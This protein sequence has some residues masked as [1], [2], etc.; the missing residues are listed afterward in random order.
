MRRTAYLLPALLMALPQAVRKLD[1]AR[2]V[3]PIFA[4]NCVVCHGPSQQ[5]NGLRLDS[6]EA[7]LKGSNAGPVVV[8]GDSAGSRLVHRITSADP[9]IRMPLGGKPL[10]PDQIALLRAWIEQREPAGSKHWSFQPIRRS[11]VPAVANRAWVRNPI[12]AFI[13]ARLERDKIEPSAEADAVTL[14]RRVTLDLTGL[15]PTPQDAAE[16]LADQRP[17]AYERL[18]DRLL[19]SPHYGEK[20]ARH[21]LDLARYADSDGY[22][23]DLVRGHA[24]RYRHW[25]IDALN[26]GMPFDRFTVE[27]I[28]GDLLPRATVEQR[29]ATGFHRNALKNREAGVHPDQARFEEIVDRTNTVGAAWLGLTLGCA[30][31]HDHKFDPISQKDYYQFFAF[32]DSAG[33]AAIDA[34]LPG[35][36]GPHLRARPKYATERTALLAKYEIPEQQAAWE[37]NILRAMDQPGVNLDW[38]FVV[39][40][41]RASFD[42]AERLLRT[43][44]ARRSPKRAE[45]LA[46]YFVA[47]AGPEIAK[48]KALLA[49]FKE[50]RAKLAALEKSLP[51][52]SQA[53]VLEENPQPVIT[54][55]ALRGDYRAKGIEVRP[56][57]PAALPPARPSDQPPRLR[58]AEW[59][60]SRDHP[61]TARVAVNRIW[62]ELF[63]RGIVATS[64]D[65]GAPGEKPTHP[66]LLDW[67]A[68]EFMDRGLSLKQM[69]RLMVLSAAYRQSSRQRD[70]LNDR[71][72]ANTLLA[73]QSRLRLPAELI[74]D[75]ALEASGLLNPAVGGPSIRPPQPDGV[76]KLTYNDSKWKESEG[77]DR[78]RRGLYV[79]YQRTSPHPQLVNFDAPDANTSC[80]RR[81]RSNT[82]LQA[83]NLLND[84]VF[85]E[86]AQALALR[87]LREAPAE[88]ND[89]VDYAF[90][91]CLARKP[92]P[93]ERDRVATF[94]RA[95]A[96][97]YQA[98][99]MSVRALAPN[100]LPGVEP[101]E[102]AAWVAVSRALMNL[103]EFITR[104]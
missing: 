76:S 43:D 25:L 50:L 11:P 82:P 8:P 37:A 30:Q 64:E 66:E 90:R 17:G 10:T 100:P 7:I 1:F 29:V 70:D 27:Q 44:P 102:T 89:R 74:R 40:S 95:Q 83:L 34:P 21:W 84:P 73:R 45:E 14:L 88:W 93:A 39:T 12:D 22:E 92:Q 38:D 36:L 97:A 6:P 4:A 96:E 51:A 20:W 81:R 104:E 5:M 61:L 58:L 56:G 87:V 9:A 52:L 19:A 13:L 91:L 80:T 48:D 42:G 47:R 77:P 85:F 41:L 35:E 31:C 79:Q 86:A 16:F 63:G 53:D 98:D 15:P 24:W 54:R 99:P 68:A 101:A 55:L 78:Y 67:L 59:L 3:Q 57:T 75:A 103:D 60:V 23:K 71:D 49:R 69:Q 18:V 26:R 32:F 33:E 94:F 46:D 28:A 72:P 65:F 2:D 62:Q